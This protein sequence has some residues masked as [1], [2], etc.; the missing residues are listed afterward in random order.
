MENKF[1]KITNREQWQALLDK[2]LF[3]TFFHNLAWEEFLEKEFKWLKFE[4]YNYQN[5]ALLSLARVRGKLISHPF[6]EYG[7]ALPLVEKIDGEIFKKDLLAEFKEPLKINL[8]PKIF[9]YFGKL[10]FNPTDSWRNTYWI[11]N[12]SQ[13]KPEELLSSLRYDIRHSIKEAE[14]QGF[15][16]QECD[17]LED[18]KAFYKLYCRTVRRHKNIPLPFSFFEF[19]SHSAKIFLLKSGKRIAT[20]SVFLS[21]PPFIHYFIT[22][23]DDHFRKQ[24][25]NHL[26]LWNVIKK[27]LGQDYQYFDLGATRKDSSLEMFKRGWRGKELPIFEITNGSNGL[28]LRQSPL[29]NI[30]SILPSCLAKKAIKYKL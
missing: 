14:G 16:F 5:L 9:E 12:V 8:H 1:S 26:L 4:H 24:G 7:G 13:L 27:Y 2:A 6:C 3:K 17:N 22:A 23:A 11:E 21:Y 18:L 28:S 29:R 19:F 20:G 25:V 10:D 15:T 30:L